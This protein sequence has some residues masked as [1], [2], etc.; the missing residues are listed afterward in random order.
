[1]PFSPV[2]SCP[3]LAEDKVIWSEY[4]TKRARPDRVHCAWLKINKDCSW[5]IFVCGG[6]IV[7][8]LYAFLLEV[9]VTLVCSIRLYPMFIR[10]NL[11]KLQNIIIY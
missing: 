6:F 3:G 7:V 10:D 8:D 1:M 5:D 2:V 4:L 9:V 11:P